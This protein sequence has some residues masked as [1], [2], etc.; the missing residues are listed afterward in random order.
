MSQQERQILS[1]SSWAFLQCVLQINPLVLRKEMCED[2]DS[3]SPLNALIL[4]AYHSPFCLGALQVL[5]CL[6]MFSQRQQI[7]DTRVPTFTPTVLIPPLADLVLLVNCSLSL[8]ENILEVTLHFH[9]LFYEGLYPPLGLQKTR[10]YTEVPP[11]HCPCSTT[12]LHHSWTK[13]VL[14]TLRDVH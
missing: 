9:L 1:K 4:C 5:Q 2:T 14:W 3:P 12:L 11:P 6:L 13:V 7:H 8:V 10:G